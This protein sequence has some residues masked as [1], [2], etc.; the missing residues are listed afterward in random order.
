[1]RA[2][3][4]MTSTPAST[5]P[6]ADELRNGWTSVALAAYRAERDEATDLIAGNVVTP[7]ERPKLQPQHES[8]LSRHF[9][10]HL[11]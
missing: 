2:R 10:P 3:A 8:A 1:M 5:E 7:F 6:N 11:W 4:G 9:K